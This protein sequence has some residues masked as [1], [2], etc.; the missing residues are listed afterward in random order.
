MSVLEEVLLEEY[1]RSVESIAAIEEELQDLPRGYLR[2]RKVRGSTYFYLQRREG[3]RV[4]SEYV[5][6]DEAPRMREKLERRKALVEAIKIQEKNVRQIER[7][8]GKGFVQGR[9]LIGSSR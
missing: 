6:R 5:S 3:K 4:I 8:L 7:A 9:A 1:E 2:E